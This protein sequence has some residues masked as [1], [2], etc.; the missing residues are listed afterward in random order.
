MEEFG[1]NL[2]VDSGELDGE[3]YFGEVCG[4]NGEVSQ[5][6]ESGGHYHAEVEQLEEEGLA[7]G[8]CGQLVD[9]VVLDPDLQLEAYWARAD[10]FPVDSQGRSDKC[11][12]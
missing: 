2:S 9:Q 7:A 3:E 6:A 4:D 8:F 11:P 1:D 12:A 5:K 10:P